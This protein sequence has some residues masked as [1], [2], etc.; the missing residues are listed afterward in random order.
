MTTLSNVCDMEPHTFRFELVHNVRICL[1]LESLAT[2]KFEANIVANFKLKTAAVA[3]HGFLV[4]T[5]FLV[6]YHAQ[7]TFSILH[8]VSSHCQFSYLR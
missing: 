6:F 4:V 8:I 2:L 3:S 7:L 1:K 5:R